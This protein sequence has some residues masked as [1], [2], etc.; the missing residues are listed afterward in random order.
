MVTMHTIAFMRSP[1]FS[2][3]EIPIIVSM[4][5]EHMYKIGASFCF[6]DTNDTNVVIV[7]I[8]NSDMY[9]IPDMII[10]YIHCLPDVVLL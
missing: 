6:I 10:R 3:T 7:R 8:R 9:S 1:E 2:F 5:K 4:P